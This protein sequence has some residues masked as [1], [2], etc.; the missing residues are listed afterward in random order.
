MAKGMLH[1]Y[2]HL[3]VHVAVIY[4]IHFYIF[5]NVQIAGN[6]ILLLTRPC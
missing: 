6:K 3:H 2:L 4:S 5:Y 1:T